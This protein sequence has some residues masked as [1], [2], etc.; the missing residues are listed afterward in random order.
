MGISAL[1]HYLRVPL[2]FSPLMMMLIFSIMLT[3]SEHAG[4]WGLPTLLIVGSWFF[5]Y[6]FA[7]L[8]HTID[9]RAEAPILSAEM[10]NPVEQRPMGTFLLVIGIYF[11]TD[12]LHAWLGTAPI[13]VLRMLLFCLIPAVV[14][15]MSITGKFFAALNP[16]AIAHTIA[17]I[18]LAYALLLLLIGAVWILPWIALRSA[19]ESLAVLWRLETF[20]PGQTLVAI[21]A[22]G[23]AIEFLAHIVF[24]YCWLAMFACIGGT[25]YEHR[26]ELEFEAAESPERKAARANAMLERERDKIMDRIFA[27]LRGG[28]LGNAGE[29]MRKLI[30]ESPRPLDEC[31]W[32]YARAINIDQRLASF[33]AQLTLPK[34]LEARATGEAITIVRERLN[35]VPEFRPKTSGELLRLAQ[36]ARDAGDRATARKLLFEFDRHFPNDPMVTVA[37]QLQQEL[38]R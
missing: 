10:I 2:Y 19:S 20:L 8:D 36:L 13:A 29:T 6:G 15:G 30:N 27:E 18:P 35:A 17:R 25:L 34:L 37:S 3:V 28:A 11:L 12:E 23:L 9:G 16:L 32:L 24:M 5:K 1:L 38:Q 26:N 7:V 31:R 21:G 14:A 22:K 4:L 33:L